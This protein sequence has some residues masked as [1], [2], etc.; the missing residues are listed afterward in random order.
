MQ[1]QSKQTTRVFMTQ[2]TDN[3]SGYG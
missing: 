3:Y 2:P 1:V